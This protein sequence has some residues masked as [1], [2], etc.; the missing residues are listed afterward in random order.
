MKHLLIGMLRTWAILA[1]IYAP[2]MIII[3]LFQGSFDLPTEPDHTI[4]LLHGMLFWV[5]V[6]GSWLV[7]G[8]RIHIEKGGKGNEGN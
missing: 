5:L 7:G 2:G 1:M 6:V 4:V 8:G 3:L